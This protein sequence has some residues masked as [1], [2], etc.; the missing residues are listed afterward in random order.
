[1]LISELEELVDILDDIV[2]NEDIIE[3]IFSE[4]DETDII[5][6][7]IL[8]MSD[9][10]DENQCAISEP[11]F[12]ETMIESVKEIMFMNYDNFFQ[13]YTEMEDELDELIDIAADLFYLHVIPR[14]SYIDTFEKKTSKE[15]FERM[16]N[17]LIELANVPQSTQ[18]TKEWYE[19]RHKLITA[20]NAYRAFENDSI[21]NQLIYE[22]CQPLKINEIENEDNSPKYESFNTTTPMHWGQ[23][24]EPVSVMYYEK[25]YSTKVSEY[26]CI[27]HD[28]YK[29]I[30][31]SPDGIMSDPSLPRFGRMLEIKNI[32]NRDIDGIPKKEYWIQMQLQM[33]TCDLNECDFLE[34]RFIEY[35]AYSSFIKDGTFLKSEK[36]EMKGVIMYF[37]CP[38]GKPKYIYKPLDLDYENFEEWEKE[39]MQKCQNEQSMTW[40]KNTYWRLEEVSCVLVLRNREWFQSNIKQLEDV[41]NIILK[42][43][44]TGYEHRAPNK[45]AKKEVKPSEEPV[46]LLNIDKLSGKVT[47][48]QTKGS[49][50]NKSSRSNSIT[51]ASVAPFFK[52]RTESIDETKENGIIGLI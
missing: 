21:R 12:H 33:E 45:R 11:D 3:K 43:R 31:A 37:S 25:T 40:V 26:G 19:S 14:R 38:D 16:K 2:P 44:E 18:R 34:T 51:D 27:Q 5:N 4:E 15:E 48:N 32:V 41:W 6:T 49:N 8:C 42:E 20:S 23:K 47:I 7:C 1:M 39:Q 52:I 29:F 10:I 28:K 46:C 35:D 30:G 13:T 36:N 17:R 50:S 22:K 9:Y 24:Y